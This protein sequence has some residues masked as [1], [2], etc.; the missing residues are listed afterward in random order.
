INLFRI[1]QE[2]LHNIL[3]HAQATEAHLQLLRQ[4]TQIVLSIEDNGVGF[5]PKTH[6]LRTGIG[7]SNIRYRAEDVLKGHVSIESSPGK[8]TF[9][10]VEIP[11]GEEK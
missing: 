2:M 4:G 9:I 5:Q 11:V 8:G 7:L 1:A 3:Q 6:T 10:A